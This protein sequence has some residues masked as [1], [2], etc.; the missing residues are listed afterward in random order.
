VIGAAGASGTAISFS[1]HSVA[2]RSWPRCHSAST[3]ASVSTAA[4]SSSRRP[5]PQAVVSVSSQASSSSRSTAGSL[6]GSAAG[7]GFL[8][9]HRDH[10]LTPTRPR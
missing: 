8:P 1:S 9:N 3:W 6:G 10:R 4:S 5:S 2:R 7:A